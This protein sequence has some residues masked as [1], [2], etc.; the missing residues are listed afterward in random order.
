M[1]LIKKIKRG[2][3]I[4]FISFILILLLLFRPART[5]LVRERHNKVTGMTAI[6]QESKSFNF[7]KKEGERVA[8]TVESPYMVEEAGEKKHLKEPVV[9]LHR[10]GGNEFIV[11]GSNGNFQSS[12]LKVDLVDGAN[13]ELPGGWILNTSSLSMDEKNIV[14]SGGKVSF[15]RGNIKGVADSLE[16][17]TEKNILYLK[18]NISINVPISGQDHYLEMSA[19]T[20]PLKGGTGDMDGIIRCS[21]P[22][23][24][25]QSDSGLIVLTETSKIKDIRLKNITDGRYRGT[26]FSAREG[27]FHFDKDGKEISGIL[28]SDNV[29]LLLQK[30]V[31]STLRSET[32]NLN[33]KDGEITGVESKNRVYLSHGTWKGEGDTIIAYIEKNIIQKGKLEGNVLFISNAG[34]ISGKAA[35]VIENGSEGTVSGDAHL[36]SPDGEAFSPK[37]SYKN[38]IFKSNDGVYGYWFKNGVIN[39]SAKEFKYDEKS[40]ILFLS[41]ECRISEESSTILSDKMAI[42]RDH[43]IEADG[44]L[45]V[46]LRDMRGNLFKVKG[47]NLKYSDAEKRAYLKGGAAGGCVVA[48]SIDQRAQSEEMVLKLTDKMR[49]KT[50]DGKG[51]S[52]LVRDDVEARG[53]TIFYDL[54]LRKGNIAAE[55]VAIIN[56]KKP[57]KRILRGKAFDIFPEGISM[58]DASGFRGSLEGF[59]GKKEL[60]GGKTT[61]TPH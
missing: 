36:I 42:S 23:I 34:R 35:E 40:R 1:N 15:E 2:I 39:F 24:A 60:R 30:D 12:P 17:D 28:L 38:D 3:I 8:F 48:T 37:I 4:L 27:L 19:I 57:E 53:D 5:F 61:N 25:F 10:A 45:T 51:H 55:K 22:E 49:L 52:E 56:Q 26:S 16:M 11:K 20:V 46:E 18:G 50:I 7:E 54:E 21:G 43:N 41:G 44:S 58:A 14:K 31:K 13:A 47:E 59:T 32:L 9:H 33:L 29:N 6:T